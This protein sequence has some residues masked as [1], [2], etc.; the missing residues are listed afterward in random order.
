MH[1]APASASGLVSKDVAHQS[2]G[3][4]VAVTRKPLAA[5]MFNSPNVS[6]AYR[7]SAVV[8]LSGAAEAPSS[9]QPR[10]TT[11][12]A[13]WISIIIMILTLIQLHSFDLAFGASPSGSFGIGITLEKVGHGPN[14]GLPI[15]KEVLPNGRAFA[16]GDSLI[17]CCRPQP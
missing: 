8:V 10:A 7:R 9:A 2:G 4:A 5:S 14:T 3:H 17:P 16:R 15:I 13:P 1:A 12:R 6:S 11:V